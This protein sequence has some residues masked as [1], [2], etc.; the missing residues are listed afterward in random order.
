MKLKTKLPK[1]IL[2]I[3]MRY[4]LLLLSAFKNLWI[5]YLVFTPLTV[6]PVY[7]LLKLFFDVSLLNSN[8]IVVNTGIEIPIELVE[9]CIAGAAYYLLLIL[10]LATPG[11]KIKKRFLM[12]VFSFASLLFLNIIRIIILSLIYINGYSFFDTAH[13]IL[14]HLMSIALVVAIWFAEVKI[15]KIKEIPFYSDFKFLVKHIKKKK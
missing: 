4:P 14:W 1:E 5:F 10:N 15:F 8:I 3:I 6:F 7:F 2:S 12:I 9:A 13:W 11:I